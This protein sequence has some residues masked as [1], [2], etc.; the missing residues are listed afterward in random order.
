MSNE[1]PTTRQIASRGKE[2]QKSPNPMDKQ[3]GVE[4]QKAFHVNLGQKETELL[5]PPLLNTLK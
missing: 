1:K 5:N 2:R 3:E 4:N